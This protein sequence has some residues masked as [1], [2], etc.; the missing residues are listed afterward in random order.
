[1][2]ILMYHRL[3]GLPGPM[4]IPL[5][6]FTAQMRLLAEGPYRA[7]TVADLHQAVRA[8]HLPGRNAVLITFDDGYLDT[9]TDALPV[10]DACGLPAAMAVCGGYLSPDTLPRRTPHSS[11]RFADAAQ[12]L[13]WR[14]SGRDVAA[15]SYTHPALPPLS[16]AALAWQ[17]AVDH[18]VLSGVLGEPP[19]LFAYPYGAH[20]ER[21]REVVA[22]LYPMALATDERHAP[23]A[24]RPHVLPRVQVSPHWD[25]EAFRA[26]LATGA[27]PRTAQHAATQAGHRRIEGP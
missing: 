3:G 7:L 19:A 9:I 21:V 1:M 23:N 6:T 4:S 27:D 15:H 11:Q 14:D 8:G 5:I 17:T 12:V 22:R 13:R 20:D 2:H 26:A 25:L 16:D 10:L 18:E 24:G